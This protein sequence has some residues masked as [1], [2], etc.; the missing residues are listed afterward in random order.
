MI[1]FL[2]QNT[3]IIAIRHQ[4]RELNSDMPYTLNKV[5]H[6]WQDKLSKVIYYLDALDLARVHA[7]RLCTRPLVLT[8]ASCLLHWTSAE[9]TPL[10]IKTTAGRKHF[11]HSKPSPTLNT[12][13]SGRALDS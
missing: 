2:H 6:I 7:V 12:Q 13:C 11:L 9:E 8:W 1:T 3:L 10:E 4:G 5:S